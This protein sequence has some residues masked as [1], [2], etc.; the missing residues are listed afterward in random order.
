MGR[1][2]PSQY[3]VR[4][5][6]K[7]ILPK[8]DNR[9][10]STQSE[11]DVFIS[12]ALRVHIFVC[13]YRNLYYNKNAKTAYTEANSHF[14][15]CCPSSINNKVQKKSLLKPFDWVCMGPNDLSSMEQWGTLRYSIIYYLQYLYVGSGVPDGERFTC[16]VQLLA[17]SRNAVN[18][19]NEL[20]LW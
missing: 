4:W 5:S 10:I 3:C 7:Q 12:S 11:W 17:V 1:L 6:V 16:K 2:L 15:S 14:I 18:V 19:W 8:W 9:Q 20:F 13:F